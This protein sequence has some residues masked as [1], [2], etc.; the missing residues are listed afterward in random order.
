MKVVVLLIRNRVDGGAIRAEFAPGLD[1]STSESAQLRNNTSSTSSSSSSTSDS[2]KSNLNS[3]ANPNARDA[4]ATISAGATEDSLP[5]Q[6]DSH[7]T[8]VSSALTLCKIVIALAIVG[9]IGFLVARKPRDRKVT[10]APNDPP[11]AT[12]KAATAHLGDIGYYLDA[13]GTVTPVATVSC[14]KK[15]KRQLS[16]ARSHPADAAPLLCRES[17]Y[18]A[19]YSIACAIRVQRVHFIVIGRSRLEVRHAHAEDR[20]SMGLI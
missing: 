7:Y 14:E 18:R 11:A 19:D 1:L 10:P 3:F 16:F 13:L 5:W 8:P 2:T 9:A 4:T 20:I 6:D 17:V 15:C 12:I